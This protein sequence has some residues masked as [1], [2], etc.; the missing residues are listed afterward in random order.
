MTIALSVV[1]GSNVPTR[2]DRI[3]PVC[4][5]VVAAVPENVCCE[6][7]AWVPVGC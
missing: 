4:D 6:V 7:R 3:P 5:G 2:D 1:V